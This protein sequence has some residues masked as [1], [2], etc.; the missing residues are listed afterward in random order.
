METGVAT[1]FALDGVGFF[2][3]RDRHDILFRRGGSFRFDG[4]GFLVD[5]DGRRLQGQP[6]RFGVFAPPFVTDVVVGSAALTIIDDAGVMTEWSG[7]GRPLVEWRLAVYEFPGPSQLAS[8]ASTAYAETPG[9][10]RPSR[11][12]GR[13]VPR[14]LE[15]DCP[16]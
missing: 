14:A 9:S 16:P 7:H 8:V 2:A 10:G 15:Q 6:R 3:V 4:R 12:P 1:D 5:A 11:S 13:V